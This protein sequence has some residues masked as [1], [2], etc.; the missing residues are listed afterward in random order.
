MRLRP[1]T[2]LVPKPLLPLGD[3]TILEYMVK[4]LSNQGF[5]KVWLDTGKLV[6]YERAFDVIETWMERGYSASV[7]GVN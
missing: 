3:M 5:D 1:F 6:D 7:T 2:Y 4:S